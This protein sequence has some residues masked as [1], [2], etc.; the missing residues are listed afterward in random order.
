MK[1]YYISGIIIALKTK[2]VEHEE[3]GEITLDSL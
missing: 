2:L 3:K 1:K